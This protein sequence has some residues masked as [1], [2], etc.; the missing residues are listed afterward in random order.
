[1]NA[2]LA[3]TTKSL[4]ETCGV[5]MILAICHFFTVQLVDNHIN[6]QNGHFSLEVPDGC[7]KVL[8]AKGYSGK[9]L[10]FGIRPED[11]HRDNA[12][13]KVFP[14]ATM[15]TTINVSELLGAES[16]LYCKIGAEEFIAKVN[17][18]DHIA[19]GE[20]VTVGMDINKGHFFD[21]ET[22]TTVY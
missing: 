1:E 3:I 9:K 10:I 14:Q 21:P 5:R 19:P 12:F 6:E 8:K 18:R 15:K 11:I 2:Q 13:L 7:L 4:S 22:E 20:V 17:S 16:Q